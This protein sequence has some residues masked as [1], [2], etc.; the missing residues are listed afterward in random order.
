MSSTTITITRTLMPWGLCKLQD[1]AW[2]KQPAGS[3][4]KKSFY[5]VLACVRMMKAAT[6]SEFSEADLGAWTKPPWPEQSLSDV[7]WSGIKIQPGSDHHLEFFLKATSIRKLPD[8]FRPGKPR[9]KKEKVRFLAAKLTF[10]VCHLLWT[11]LLAAWSTFSQ[12]KV[13]GAGD[14]ISNET[15]AHVVNGKVLNIPFDN[16][17]PRP[18][19]TPAWMPSRSLNCGKM[20]D[21]GDKWA[22]TSP[23][24]QAD[25]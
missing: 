8:C 18:R 13:K 3:S 24:C 9:W 16:I 7:N 5:R 22:K 6:K 20:S 10:L 4:W 17:A 15:C 14:D 2:S 23:T 19:L 12:S 21:I 11:N 25:Q 1:E